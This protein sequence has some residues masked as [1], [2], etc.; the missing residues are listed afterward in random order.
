M[1]KRNELIL[2]V[3]EVDEQQIGRQTDFKAGGP[4]R[5]PDKWFFFYVYIVKKK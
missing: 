5:F 4:K 1:K 3:L 2:M